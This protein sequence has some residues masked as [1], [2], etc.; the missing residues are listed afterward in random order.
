[1]DPDSL[2]TNLDNL[3]DLA[4]SY[5][6]PGPTATSND[7]ASATASLDDYDDYDDDDDDSFGIPSSIES[8][9]ATAVPS[10]FLSQMADP[11]AHSSI[12]SEIE[13]GHFPDW[14]NDLPTSVKSWFETAYGGSDASSSDGPTSPGAASNVVVASGLLG[15]AGI[16]AAAVL[17]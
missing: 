1:M 8:V 6:V 7:L 11:T 5:N 9:L 17:L 12:V 4:T 3:D 14:Y 16:L 13:D 10:S 2:S 15:A